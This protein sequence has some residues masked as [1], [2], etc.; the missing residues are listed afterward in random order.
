MCAAPREG[1]HS[2]IPAAAPHLES[3]RRNHPTWVVTDMG[4]G[5]AGTKVMASFYAAHQTSDVLL[6]MPIILT[7]EADVK[8]RISSR[9][10]I[11]TVSM[12]LRC[13]VIFVWHKNTPTRT[14]V[15]H[16]RES[17]PP[18]LTQSS[19]CVMDMPIGSWVQRW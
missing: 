13:M 3:G 2:V 18:F 10:G 16:G 8:L 11:W 1:H 19:A 12:M 9:M 4:H 14:S 15:S 5:T 6:V 7:T 17:G